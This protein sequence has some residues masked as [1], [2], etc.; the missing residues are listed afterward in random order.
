MK[1]SHCGVF[2]GMNIGQCIH[3]TADGHGIVSSLGVFKNSASGTYLLE[4]TGLYFFGSVYSR[5]VVLVMK[6]AYFHL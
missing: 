1:Y 5:V 3:F 2:C 4:N 6:Y